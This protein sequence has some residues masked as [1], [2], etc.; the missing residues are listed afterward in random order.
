MDVK[1]L[2]KATVMV[3]LLKNTLAEIDTLKNSIEET[4]DGENSAYFKMDV[5]EAPKEVNPNGGIALAEALQ[6]ISENFH[7]N[8]HKISEG[9][10]ILEEIKFNN[11]DCVSILTLMLELK[12]KQARNLQE[13]LKELGI[14]IN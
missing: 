5:I 4:F 13:G 1:D 2:K 3:D 11:S 10:A 6:I 7:K 12:K 8:L 14:E 9:V